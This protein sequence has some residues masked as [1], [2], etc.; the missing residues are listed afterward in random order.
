MGRGK[1]AMKLIE[2]EKSRKATYHKRKNGIMKKAHELSTLCGIDSCLIIY[3]PNSNNH[4]PETWPQDPIEIQRIISKY[5]AKIAEKRP[6]NYDVIEFFKDRKNK[7][8]AETSKL[9]KERLKMLY[10]TWDNSF[11]NLGEDQLRMFANALDAKIEGCRE[12]INMLKKKRYLKEKAV[13]SVVS[14]N[15]SHLCFLQNTS[16]TQDFSAIM[17]KAPQNSDDNNGMME[18][19]SSSLCY[20]N[21]GGVQLVQPHNYYSSLQKFPSQN[22]MQYHEANLQALP[23][24]MIQANYGYQDLLQAH[25]PYN[26]MNMKK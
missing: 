15:R 19:Y 24:L 23:P 26:Y 22:I 2:K 11:N 14:S 10:P 17:M 12:K 21:N 13:E 8:E 16:E 4:Q 25:Q 7:V 1:L 9:H 5:E 3:S 20:Y 6:K 18:D